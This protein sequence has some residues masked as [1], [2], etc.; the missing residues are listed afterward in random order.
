M[1]RGNARGGK[2][3]G[4][5]CPAKGD[6]VSTTETQETTDTVLRRIAWLSASAASKRFESLMHLFNQ[7]SLA[8]CFHELDGRKAVGVDGSDPYLDAN[9]FVLSLLPELG[10]MGSKWGGAG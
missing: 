8:A 1:K 10:T 6:V 9:S 7:G 4:W 2:D 5:S 3:P